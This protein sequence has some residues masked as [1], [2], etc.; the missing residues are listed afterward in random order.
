M[1]RNP[2]RHER[3][4]SRRTK[5]TLTGPAFAL[6]GSAAARR[7]RGASLRK[8]PLTLMGVGTVLGA[9][10]IIWLG[11]GGMSY[12]TATHAI[13]MERKNA[14]ESY[15][16]HDPRAM[17]ANRNFME[18]ARAIETGFKAAFLFHE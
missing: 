18:R 13:S 14:E 17:E 16:N 2:Y 7:S 9:M 1:R 8:W 3:S 4:P 12:S 5:T 6:V 11:S 10:V 15:D